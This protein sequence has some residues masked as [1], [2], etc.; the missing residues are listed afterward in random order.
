MSWRDRPAQR[1]VPCNGELVRHHR[2]RRG[3]TQAELGKESGF[4]TRLVAKAES[5]GSLDCDTIETLAA[6]LTTEA[7]PVFPEDLVYFPKQLARKF[8]E[9]YAEFERECAVHCRDFLAEDF[10][11]VVPGDPAIL[12]FAGEYHGYTDFEKFWKIFFSVMRR[13]NKR[14]IIDSMRVIA[15]GNEVVVL[16]NEMAAHI[17][18]TDPVSPTPL[19]FVFEFERGKLKR[20]E[21][22]FD[23]ASAQQRVLE[24]QRMAQELSNAT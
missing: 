22:H 2:N 23:V 20:L 10:M 11:L 12:P 24:M 16:T 14:T 6:T 4:T 5:G 13:H 3:W 21:D 19:A 17:D 18:Q 9:N 15:E 7:S 8:I 1:S